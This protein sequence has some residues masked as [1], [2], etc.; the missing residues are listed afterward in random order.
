M[1]K[2]EHS[3]SPAD[4]DLSIVRGAL[5]GD[6]ASGEALASRLTCIPRMLAS[7]NRRAGRALTTHDLEDLAQETA[8]LVWSKLGRFEGNGSLEQWAYR[9]CF[10]EF[11]NHLRAKNRVRRT[12]SEIDARDVEIEAAPPPQRRMMFLARLEA[13]LADIGPPD[14][15]V[16]SLK[17]FEEMT[18]AEIGSALGMSPNTAKAKYY[19]VLERLRGRFG[20]M[21]EDAHS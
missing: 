13:A 14:S 21:R 2:P 15:D 1:S 18:F 6:R 16:I 19:R 17:H 4:G 9:F 5:D 20:A 7:I 11:M 10:L 12:A 3:Q 8:L